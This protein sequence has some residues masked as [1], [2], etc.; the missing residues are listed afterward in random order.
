MR[1]ADRVAGAFRS[2]P[3]AIMAALLVAVSAAGGALMNALVRILT[4]HLHPFEVAFF[5]NFFGLL[6]VLPLLAQLGFAPMKMRH[7]G[8]MMFSSIGHVAGMLSFFV[9][10]TVMP[11]TEAAALSFTTPLFATAG[12]ALLLGEIVR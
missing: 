7:L 6:T 2:I 3:P 5:R 1:P 8:P 12:A 9:A 4:D 10:L 11:L